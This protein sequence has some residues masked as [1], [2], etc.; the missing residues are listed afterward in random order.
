[1]R[2][3]LLALLFF[4]AACGSSSAQQP[5]VP[6][7]LTTAE[8]QALINQATAPLNARIAEL[9]AQDVTTFTAGEPNPVQVAGF[10]LVYFEGAAC[11]GNAYLH[12]SGP[13]YEIASSAV[14]RGI[15]TRYTLPGQTDKAPETYAVVYPGESLSSVPYASVLNGQLCFEEA[16]TVIGYRVQ[17]NDDP[18]AYEE[19]TGVPAGGFLEG[20]RLSTYSAAASLLESNTL[21]MV[22]STGFIMRFDL[23]TAPIDIR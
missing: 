2:Y 16:G 14:R 23:N 18:V 20:T 19:L 12:A 21:D 5:P 3:L 22:T 6:T 9:E 11:Q 10:G 7:G 4:V 15:V 8:V 13:F 1:M 17:Q